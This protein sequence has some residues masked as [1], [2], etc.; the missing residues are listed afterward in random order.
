MES[1]AEPEQQMSDRVCNVCCFPKNYRAYRKGK[2]TCTSCLNQIGKGTLRVS[3]PVTGA[4]QGQSVI[5]AIGGDND[6]NVEENL[7]RNEQFEAQ[8]TEQKNQIVTLTA[9]REQLL[10]RV[11]ELETQ[12]A[13]LSLPGVENLNLNQGLEEIKEQSEQEINKWRSKYDKQL[14]LYVK[15]QNRYEALKLKKAR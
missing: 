4:Y 8:I 6:V 7:R 12:V 3:P 11:R 5:P 1:A 9:E 2:A 13:E 15:L 10:V 14:E